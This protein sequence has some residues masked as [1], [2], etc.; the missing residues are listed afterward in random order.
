MFSFTGTGSS[1]TVSCCLLEPCK[2]E[3]SRNAAL[4]RFVAPSLTV[5]VHERFLDL[6]QG[7]F[8]TFFDKNFSLYFDV[9]PQYQPIILW[10]FLQEFLIY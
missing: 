2:F 1:M 5:P 10:S 6:S 3:I 9:L 4:F 7:C 8:R